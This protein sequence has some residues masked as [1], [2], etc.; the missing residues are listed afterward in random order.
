[1]IAAISV[2]K[3]LN[4]SCCMIRINVHHFQKGARASHSNVVIFIL[5][6]VHD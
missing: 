2:G 1:M 6:Y 4:D 3:L 5:K